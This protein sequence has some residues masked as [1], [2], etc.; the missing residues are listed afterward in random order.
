MQVAGSRLFVPEDLFG[1]DSYRFAAW[2]SV[3]GWAT[4]SRA[5]Q[6]H[7]AWFARTHAEGD[8]SPRRTREAHPESWQLMTGTGRRYF[9]D[10]LA[11]DDPNHPAWDSHW[12]LSQ[13]EMGGL[14]VTPARNLVRNV[15]VGPDATHITSS[16]PMPASVP[17]Q[18]PLRIPS[19]SRSTRRSSSAWS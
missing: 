1:Q 18:F 8:V 15:G 4:W 11:T 16:R 7:R 5:W 12:W 13:I 10:V 17:M 9:K 19:V 6:R 14:A 2:S 3:W